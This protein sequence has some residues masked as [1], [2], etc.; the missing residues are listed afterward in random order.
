MTHPMFRGFNEF[1]A[2][3]ERAARLPRVAERDAAD[4]YL[5]PEGAA[6]RGVPMRAAHRR[7]ARSR[8]DR[9]SYSVPL[10]PPPGWAKVER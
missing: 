6:P 2:R 9:E 3:S 5:D 7:I 10:E 8:D 1:V 4:E